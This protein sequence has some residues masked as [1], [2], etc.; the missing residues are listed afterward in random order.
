MYTSTA[1]FPARSCLG[2]IAAV[3]YEKPIPAVS[4]SAQRI[5][6]FRRKFV[7]RMPVP[8]IPNSPIV[9]TAAEKLQ[10][11]YAYEKIQKFGYF[12]LG[13]CSIVRK[14]KKVMESKKTV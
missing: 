1:V 6:S 9:F 5:C 4:G 10:L 2:K 14:R 13:F 11:F 8:D 12:E 7:C 3:Q